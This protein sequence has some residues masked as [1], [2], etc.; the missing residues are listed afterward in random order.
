MSTFTDRELDVMTVLW[1]RG[2]ATVA[3]VREQLDDDLAYTTVLTVLRTLEDK[4]HVGHREAGKAHRYFAKVEA[5]TARKTALSKLVDRVFGG[6]AEL[7]LTHLVSDRKL[8]AAE[9]KRLREIVD[10]QA[11]RRKKP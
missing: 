4:G 8:S 3:E 10:R 11:P 5:Q 9:I 7:L 1:N 6:S 2:P